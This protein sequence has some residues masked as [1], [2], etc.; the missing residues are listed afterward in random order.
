[1][2]DQHHR[3]RRFIDGGDQGSNPV[4]ALRLVPVSLLDAAVS[5]GRNTDPVSRLASR[6]ELRGPAQRSSKALLRCPVETARALFVGELPC[7]IQGLR[8]N[9]LC[10]SR[11]FQTSSPGPVPGSAGAWRIFATLRQTPE[12]AALLRGK[13]CVWG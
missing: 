2:R 5:R 12:F 11:L 1:M 8:W 6:R 4:L 10:A 13:C 3:L 9:Q 7:L